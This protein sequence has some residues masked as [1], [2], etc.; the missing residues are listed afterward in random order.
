MVPRTNGEVTPATEYEARLRGTAIHRLIEWLSQGER[1]GDPAGRLP[2]LA[3]ELG[4]TD[5][6]PRLGDWF[7]EARRVVTAPAL[8]SV[9]RPGPETAAHNEVSLLFEHAG[10]PVQRIVDRLLVSPHELTIVDYKT[11]RL[12]A[13]ADIHAL[14]RAHAAQ[15]GLYAIGARRLWPDGRP[16]RLLVVFTAGPVAVELPVDE[17]LRAADV[18]APSRGE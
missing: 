17:A 13:G 16:V 9:F 7:E 10:R 4:I 2:G 15:L 6:D 14:A 3:R 18:P 8:A 12:S 5:D 1:D 11:R